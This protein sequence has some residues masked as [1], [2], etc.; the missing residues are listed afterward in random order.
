VL[1]KMGRTSEA[2]RHYREVLDSLRRTL[3]PEHPSTITAVNNLGTL[4]SD[5]RRP[6]EAEPLLRQALEGRRRALTDDHPLTVQSIFALA[7]LLNAQRRHAEAEPLYAELYRRSATAQLAPQQAARFMSFWGV[8]LV[9]LE[10]Y[11]EAEQPLREA[12]RRLSETGQSMTRE[13]SRVL[14]ALAGV[15]ARTGRTDEAERWR[16]EQE[17]LLATT[18]AA[19]RRPA[20][21]PN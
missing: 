21:S 14:E 1:G 4:L 2:E 10:R 19:T 9:Q 16:A 18:R 20:T 12:H 11:A 6:D 8:C 13:M 17:A 5:H 7:N 3:G 15:C